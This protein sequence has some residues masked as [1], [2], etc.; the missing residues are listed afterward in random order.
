MDVM[1]RVAR[2]HNLPVLARLFRRHPMVAVAQQLG[3]ATDTGVNPLA[4]GKNAEDQPD[5]PYGSLSTPLKG[6]W[7]VRDI[8]RAVIA[9]PPKRSPSYANSSCDHLCIHWRIPDEK[10]WKEIRKRVTENDET[11]ESMLKIDIH[12]SILNCWWITRTVTVFHPLPLPAIS[13][14]SMQ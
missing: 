1:E 3:M 5:V 9:S 14:S 10:C 6:T 2:R 8:L 12:K 13:L 4:P 7:F 11:D